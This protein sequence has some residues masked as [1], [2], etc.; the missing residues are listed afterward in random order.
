MPL[1]KIP[2]KG[3]GWIIKNYFNN[4]KNGWT[5]SCWS[6]AGNGKIKFLELLRPYL[7]ELVRYIK[8]KGEANPFDSKYTDYFQMRRTFRNYYP[9]NT[10]NL[11]AGFV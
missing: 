1:H 7:I 6:K 8:I 3:W 4:L 10:N 5:F 2:E 9:I 11:T